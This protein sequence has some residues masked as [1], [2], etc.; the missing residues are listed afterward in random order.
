MYIYIYISLSLYKYLYM[1]GEGVLQV[2]NP[3]KAR[4][5]YFGALKNKEAGGPRAQGRPTATHCSPRD[6]WQVYCYGWP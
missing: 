1:E 3:K 4:A 6:S 2:G 5:A